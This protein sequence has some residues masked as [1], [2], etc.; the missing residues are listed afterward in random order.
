MIETLQKIAL[1]LPF[2][3][4]IE[5]YLV[6]HHLVFDGTVYLWQR[7]EVVLVDDVARLAGFFF[8]VGLFPV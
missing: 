7:L 4:F 2:D 8:F 1:I 5:T 3:I 6:F